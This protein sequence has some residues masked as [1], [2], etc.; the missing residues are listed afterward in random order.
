MKGTTLALRL[1][2]LLLVLVLAACAPSEPA[3][4]SAERPL[5]MAFVPSV[6]TQ[7]LLAVV[8]PFA[9]LLE[10]ETGYRIRAEV[11]TSYVAV[12]EAMGAKKVDIAQLSPFAY[13][14]ARQKHG[15]ETILT[16]VRTGKPTYQGYIV[17]R[18]DSGINTLDDLRGKKFAFVEPTSTSGHI[19]PKA[20]LVQKG[21][22]PDRFF[23]SA[24][25]AG[26]HDKVLIALMSKQVDGGAVY[27][28]ARD[29]PGIV[30]QYPDIKTATKIIAETPPIPN[31]TIVVRPDLPADMVAK[32][33]EAIIKVSGT[34]EGETLLKKTYRIDGFV[35]SKDADYDPVRKAAEVLKI[36]LEQAIK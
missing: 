9:Q 29:L 11:P 10:K 19:Y 33:R 34:P 14:L 24:T 32:L 26:G 12:V 13:V 1:G 17:V 35:P 5:V 6:E 25:F 4:G 16:F 8:T 20:L 27:D 31:D 21:I 18:S 15:V 3:L 22:D 23:A 7:Q 30:Q 28:G 36:D 2:A